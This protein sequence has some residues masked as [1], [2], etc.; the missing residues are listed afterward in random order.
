MR[1]RTQIELREGVAVDVLVTP[2]LYRVAKQRG[3]NL[4]SDSN[5]GDDD[6]FTSYIKMLYCAAINAWEVDAVDN[7]GKG[8]FP[9]RYS[10]F[11]EWAWSDRARLNKMIQFLYEALTGKPLV[12]AVSEVKKKKTR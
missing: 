12:Q 9:Y 1:F 3:I 2:A 8:D 4:V 5:A 7:P 6:P 10:E 11:D